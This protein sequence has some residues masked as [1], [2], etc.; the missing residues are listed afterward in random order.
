MPRYDSFQVISFCYDFLPSVYGF[1][2]KHESLG[3]YLKNDFHS[4]GMSDEIG[5]SP[6]Q[7]WPEL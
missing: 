6:D 3:Q 1:P 2:L 7:K 4:H 5:G